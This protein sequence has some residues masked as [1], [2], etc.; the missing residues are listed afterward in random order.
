MGALSKTLLSRA[1][2]LWGSSNLQSPTT[3]SLL[4]GDAEQATNEYR[5]RDS[6]WWVGVTCTA[7]FA[8]ALVGSVALALGNP[9]GSFPRPILF[10]A[11]F[12][13]F[14]GAF[15]LL[16]AWI[17]ADY[18]RSRLVVSRDGV[19]QVGVFW[20]TGI[21]FDEVQE[22]RWRAI[23]V[24]GRLKLR[25]RRARMTIH[26][27][28]LPNAVRA[29]AVERFRSLIPMERQVG[30]EEFGEGTSKREVN[31][32]RALVSSLVL[33]GFFAG[34][35]VLQLVVWPRGWIQGPDML[36]LGIANALGVAMAGRS[37]WRAWRR[38]RAEGGGE[39]S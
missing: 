14:W 19:V 22:A 25:D 34:S 10:A 11:V 15:T 29:D 28:N 38:M 21:E 8:V 26:F 1:N 17:L 35:A 6:H 5:P 23:P 37:A 32:R 3:G 30:W 7:F 36:K 31:P 12:G 9:D 20:S 4:G 24:G 39:R 33:A 16:S 18:Y 13:L 27:A 2:C